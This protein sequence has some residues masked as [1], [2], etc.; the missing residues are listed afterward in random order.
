MKCCFTSD[1]TSMK[2]RG[3]RKKNSGPLAADNHPVAKTAKINPY[4]LQK[5][6][7]LK[8]AG[9]CKICGMLTLRPDQLALHMRSHTKEMSY[10]CEYCSQLFRFEGSLRRHIQK[11]HAHK[12][13]I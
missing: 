7:G 5:L 9:Q 10:Q 3:R 13:R 8:E 6:A 2:V 4:T 11:N 12:K 1:A